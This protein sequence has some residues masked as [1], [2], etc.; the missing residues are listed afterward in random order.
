[1][2]SGLGPTCTIDLSIEDSPGLLQYSIA[3]KLCLHVDM[4]WLMLMCSKPHL[5]LGCSE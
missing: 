2:N 3:L 4:L 1:M 5:A